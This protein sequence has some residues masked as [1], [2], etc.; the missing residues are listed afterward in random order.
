MTLLRK[1]QI[2]D[3]AA[4]TVVSAVGKALAYNAKQWSAGATFKQR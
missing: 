2:N 3:G 4:A 1:K